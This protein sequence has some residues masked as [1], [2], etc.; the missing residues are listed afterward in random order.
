M[1]AE[2]RE[3]LQLRL[4]YH[5]IDP[6]LFDEALTHR[7]FANEQ[8]SGSKIDNERLEFLGDAVLGLVV[9]EALFNRFAQSPEGELTRIRAEVVNAETLARVARSIGLGQVLRLGRGEE[10][11]GGRDKDNILADA[12][13]AMFGAIFRDG[14]LVSARA[15]ILSLLNEQIETSAERRE[16]TDFK[17]RLQEYLQAQRR[18]TPEYVVTAAE[19]PEHER[20]FT[21]EARCDG[22]LLGVGGGRSKKEAEQVAARHALERLNA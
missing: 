13:E 19:G 9:G 15:V 6:G 22:E 10:K 16:G 21:I 1:S 8:R 4:G 17:T 3:E 11:T 2:K 20:L 14:G 18:S 12:L 5:F 7:S